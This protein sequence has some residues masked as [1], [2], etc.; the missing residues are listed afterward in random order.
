MKNAKVKRNLKDKP[1]LAIIPAFFHFD[2]CILQ[3]PFSI[4]PN[5]EFE[6]TY[7]VRRENFLDG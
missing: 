5:S 6:F 7:D 3:F 2:F 1:R 4:W